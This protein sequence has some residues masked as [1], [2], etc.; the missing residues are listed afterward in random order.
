M[1]GVVGVSGKEKM[2]DERWCVLWDR[3]VEL[4]G[5]MSRNWTWPRARD[6]TTWMLTEDAEPMSYDTLSTRESQTHDE[7]Q[8]RAEKRHAQTEC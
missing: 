8:W 1:L 5:I 6:L 2:E 4:G 7:L 3:L